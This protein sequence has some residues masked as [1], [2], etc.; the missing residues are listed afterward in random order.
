M[1]FY[2]GNGGGILIGTSTTPFQIGK[3]TVRR[4]AR[5]V[6]NTH[7]G[8]SSSNYELVVPDHSFSVEIPWN[9]A[10]LP[11]TDAGLVPGAK[12]T[13]TFQFGTSSKTCQLTST[14]VETL[15][16]VDDNANDI[17]RAVCSGKGGAFTPPST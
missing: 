5:L 8:V 12:I 13:I 4:N 17:V 7:S 9:D 15:E 14:S 11:D 1:S 10:D 2:S 3:W 6:E 16:E